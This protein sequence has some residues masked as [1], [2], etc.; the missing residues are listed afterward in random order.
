MKQAHKDKGAEM[1]TKLTKQPERLPVNLGISEP[2]EIIYWTGLGFILLFL[3]IAPFRTGLY[4]GYLIQYEVNVYGSAAWTALFFFLISLYW[5]FRWK[6]SSVRD[7]LMLLAWGLPLSYLLSGFVAVSPYSNGKQILLHAMYAMLF[8]LAAYF[9]RSQSGNR[10]LQF[11][12][13]TSGYMVVI[14]CILNM[15]GNAY[16]RD[17]VM[18]D[19]GLRLTAVFQ[20]ANAYAAVLIAL[21]L[22]CLHFIMSSRS[23]VIVALNALMLVPLALSFSLTLSRGG[24]VVLPLILLALLPFLSVVRQI[25]FFI[26]LG[27]GFTASFLITDRIKSISLEML[28]R[29]KA[30][31]EQNGA[32]DTVSLLDPLSWKGWL[33]LVPVSIGAAALIVIL[34][35]YL[36][37]LMERKLARFAGWKWSNWIVP[38][39][40]IAL[41]GI[42]L[43]LIIQGSMVGN[44]LPQAL[45]QRIASINLQQ[46]SVLERLMMFADSLK[47]FADR[48][49]LGGGG[50]VWEALFTAYQGAPYL[51][52]QVH[53][54]FF[55]YLVETGLVG[56]IFLGGLLL[57]VFI[58]YIKNV[59]LSKTTDPDQSILYYLV[60]MSILLHSALD[61]EMSYGYIAALVFLCLGGM[62][63]AVTTELRLEGSKL[64][65]WL[66]DKT[67]GRLVP[68]MISAAAL[69]VL[70]ISFYDYQANRTFYTYLDQSMKGNNAHANQALEKAL[71]ARP[72]HPEYVLA[73]VNELNKMYNQ[74]GDSKILE[75]V[76]KHLQQ[77]SKKEPYNR[78]LVEQQFIL[79]LRKDELP[80]ALDVAYSRLE[81]SIWG[82]SLFE[83]F[84]NWYDRAV[85]LNLQ[86]G[87]QARKNND[88]AA[89]QKYWDDAIQL[90]Q[91]VLDKMKELEQLP[92][93]QMHEPFGVGPGMALSIG[94]IYYL[95]NDYKTAADVMEPYTEGNWELPASREL[96]RWYLAARMRQGEE[97][98]P[99]YDKFIGQFPDEKEWIEGMVHYDA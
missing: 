10:M 38:V 86:L 99:L 2:N 46:H 72:N 93:G 53:S 39:G 89:Q 18:E 32:A 80:E 58:F 70:I 94:Q 26:Y 56:L 1:K 6:I 62:A 13:M 79:H 49:V 75:E 24:I 52:R 96:T 41:G 17:A 5:I 9:A 78:L 69:I 57:L 71:K 35:L 11:G 90:Y 50:G 33:T 29:M 48:P 61:F 64:W 84:P 20:Y 42:G 97:H 7:A 81:S 14:Y 59:F 8:G 67:W 88:P 83:D 31:Y 95:R 87:D 36:A 76:A 55:E 47:I 73:K 23:R 92:E 3:F 30:S 85:D 25:C 44:L 28:K 27:I 54:Y 43:L 15:F 51:P 45:H 40:L 63:S 12:I 60:A 21:L 37:P 65:G 66:T 4:N 82:L 34:Q 91:T 77:L 16:F 98:P 22:G 19:Q 68:G 74:T